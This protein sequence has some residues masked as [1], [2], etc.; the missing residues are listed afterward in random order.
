MTAVLADISSSLNGFVTGPGDSVEVPLGEGGEVLHEWIFGLA[1]WRAAHGMEGGES[2]PEDDLV[3]E[4]FERVGAVLM[5]RRMFDHG[6]GPWG[7]EPPFRKPVFVLTHRTRPPLAKEGGTTFNFVDEGLET[8]LAKAKEAAAGKD[9]GVAS[10]DV[11]GQCIAGDLLDE[12]TLHVVPVFLDGG[13]RLFDGL[14]PGD[15]PLECVEAFASGGV[16][17]LR[18]RRAG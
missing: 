15:G 9:V 1:G 5:G 13:V 4:F 7:E 2:G 18:F 11:I 3:T 6:E 17:H 8:A 10:A 12:L 14:G 16:T